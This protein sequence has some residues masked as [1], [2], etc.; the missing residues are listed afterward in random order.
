MADEPAT[1]SRR[2][3]VAVLLVAFAVELVCLAFYTERF[4]LLF[5][6]RSAGN[7]MQS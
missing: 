1:R 7:W 5:K 4:E 6:E 2:V 3:R